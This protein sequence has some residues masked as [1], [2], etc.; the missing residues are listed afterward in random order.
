MKITL[1]QAE[2]EEAITQYVNSTLTLAPGTNVSIDLFSPRGSTDI[3]ASIDLMTVGEKKAADAKAAAAPKKAEEPAQTTT[4][5]AT[6]APAPVETKVAETTTP[7][8]EKQPAAAATEAAEEVPPA[9]EGKSLFG[10]L[11]RPNNA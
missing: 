1:V 4:V 5:A 2:I 6:A 3:N 11:K 10:G 9:T 8:V 7:V